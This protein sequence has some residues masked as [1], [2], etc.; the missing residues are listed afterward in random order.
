MTPMAAS[1][2]QRPEGGPGVP[3]CKPQ[4]DRHMGPFSGWA[5]PEQGNG[6][7]TPAA[8]GSPKGA[9]LQGAHNPLPDSILPATHDEHASP[10]FWP[11]LRTG[12]PSSAS[13]ANGHV[14][15]KSSDRWQLQPKGRRTKYQELRMM[16]S[17][18]MAAQSTLIIMF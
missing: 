9:G 11:S 16:A 10:T 17:L 7:M 13:G 2:R 6:L 8:S 15:P 5:S 18:E 1:V 14:K 3:T 4:N 12:F